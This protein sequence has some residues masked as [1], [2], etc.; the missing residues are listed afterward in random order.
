MAVTHI[1]PIFVRMKM[2]HILRRVALIAV[3]ACCMPSPGQDTVAEKLSPLVR[4]ALLTAQTGQPQSRT[5]NAGTAA[6]PCI[7]AFVETAGGA[8]GVL[9]DAGCR[10][11]SSFG[12]IHIAS[13]PLSSLAGLAGHSG[14]LRIE[15][16]E[17]CSLTMDSTDL[18]IDTRP[19]YA[20]TGLPQAYTGRGVVVGVQDIG[21][22]LTHPNF[23]SADMDEYRIKALW[24]QLSTDTVGSA[25]Y[26]GR[27]YV[28]RGVLLALEHSRDGLTQT[29]GTHTLGIA[30]GSGYNSAYRGMAYESDICLVSNCT[31]ANSDLIDSNDRYKYTNAT[32]ALGFQY[33]FNYAQAHGQ[34]CVIS[35]SEGYHPTLDGE[36]RLFYAVLD[37]ITG[38]GR[39]LCASAGNEGVNRSYF[40]K[41]AGTGSAGGFITSSSSTAVWLMR[42]AQPFDIRLVFYGTENDTLTISSRRAFGGRTSSHYYNTLQ[43]SSGTYRVY[44]AGYASCYDSGTKA[45]EMYVQGPGSTL[46]SDVPISLELVGGDADVEWFRYSG[47]LVTSSL[48]GSLQAGESTHNV[49]APAAADAVIGVG[50]NSYRTGFVN[51]QGEWHTFNMGTGGQWAYYSSS[52]PTLDGRVKPDVVAP[53]TNV[54]SSYSS[55]YLENNPSASDLRS[56]VE[57]FSHNGRTYVWNANSGTSMSAPVVAGAIALWL[58]ANPRLTPGECKQV[59]AKTCRQPDPALSYPNNRYGYGE[60][61]VYAGL[62]DILNL[63]V[64]IPSLS[65]HQPR[66]VQFALS[67]ERLNITAPRTQRP[68]QVR[69]YTTDGQ[70]VYNRSFSDGSSVSIDLGPLP[71]GVLAVQVNGGTAATTGSTLIR[72]K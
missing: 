44:L 72:H 58:Q 66:A 31:S 41:A 48:N 16:G 35:F 32:D 64:A 18:H 68:L 9:T 53:G 59:L 47:Y 3:V 60:I 57:H 63:P 45:Y 70:L 40:R 8:S 61:D 23:F 11:L 1:L 52:G 29:H 10:V 28:G 43:L 6:E 17:S 56:D 7:T 24:D 13:V 4:Q 36:D 69:L 54:I 67:G 65:A 38:P 62:L 5:L 51:W 25:L 21:F 15:A 20:G 19:V 34:P 22:D 42:S 55:Y 12:R 71:H 14:I 33:I 26:V 30:A 27:D 46:G 49:L 39:I 2:H 37:S 50:A